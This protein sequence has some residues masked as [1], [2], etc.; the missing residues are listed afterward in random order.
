MSSTWN[1]VAVGDVASVSGGATPRTDEPRFWGGTIGWL[2][3]KDLSDKPS[4]Y[5]SSGSRNLTEEG[6][7]SCS[8]NLLPEGAVMLTS[9]APIGYVSIAS[10]PITT[11]Q[12]FKNLVLNDGQVPLFWYYLLRESKEYLESYANGSTF[13]EISASS[14]RSLTFRVPDFATQERIAGAIGAFDDLIELNRQLANQL[15]ALSDSAFERWAADVDDRIALGEVMDRVS[16]SIDAASL[17]GDEIYLGLE[18]FGLEAA[19]LIGQGRTDGL[20]SNKIKFQ[21]GD[22]L[23]GKLRPY[24][25][26]VARP[27]FSGVC[28]TEAWVLR[29]QGSATQEYIHWLTRRVDFTAHAMAGSEGTKM[30]RA[31]WSHVT[32]MLVPT[33]EA[34]GLTEVS[35]MVRGFWEATNELERE[36]AELTKARDEL[37]PLLLSGRVNVGDVAA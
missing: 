37:L 20:A 21:S 14:L 10:G 12:G 1:L 16:E 18:H 35:Q 26:K 31:S 19:G 36:N 9:R 2:T 13:K 15:V 23:Y 28:S 32:S 11:N 8:A 17:K 4:R 5:T 29:G 30:P 6:L 7:R 22:V 27:G 24:F 33:P 34:P 25:R 3:P